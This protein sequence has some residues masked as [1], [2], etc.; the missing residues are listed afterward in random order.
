MDCIFFTQI[1]FFSPMISRKSF[2]LRTLVYMWRSVIKVERERTIIVPKTATRSQRSYLTASTVLFNE[3]TMSPFSC[4][5]LIILIGCSKTVSMLPVLNEIVTF[6][7]SHARP[8]S[9]CA[10]RFASICKQVI[11]SKC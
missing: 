4:R 5:V 6:K 11:S 10:V 1:N 7:S 9:L 3:Q 2:S 8:F